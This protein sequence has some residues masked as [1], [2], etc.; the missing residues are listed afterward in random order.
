MRALADNVNLNKD[1][2]ADASTQFQLLNATSTIGTTRST[3]SRLIKSPKSV[4]V[5]INTDD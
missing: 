5:D 1:A 4:E 2:A 3:Q